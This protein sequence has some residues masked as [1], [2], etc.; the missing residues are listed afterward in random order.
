VLPV[1]D[2]PEAENDSVSVVED[3]S[4]TFQLKATD[5]DGDPL[6]YILVTGPAHGCLELDQAT[7]QV[8]YRPHEDY[9]GADSFRFQVDDGTGEQNSLSNE[10]TVSITVTPL[11]AG[12]DF[13]GGLLTV[14]GTPGKDSIK[15]VVA[16]K[17]YKVQTN[18]GTFNVADRA[19]VTRVVVRARAGDD[20]VNVAPLSAS[21]VV[22]VY[23]GDG[24]DQIT[25]GAGNSILLGGAGNDMLTGGKGDDLLIG[26]AGLD[27][28]VGAAGSDLLIAGILNDPCRELDLRGVLD[29]WRVVV[30][31]D[32]KRAAAQP[33][34][35]RVLDDLAA[36]LLS[37]SAGVDLFVWS[38][39][40]RITDLKR[41]D[42]S[43]KL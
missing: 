5:V 25:G 1:N 39:L 38:T 6:T 30:G 23:A 13:A 41:E 8:T 32:A 9:V 10:A 28:L 18:F 37:G 16:G 19:S 33:L 2:S 7:G 24:N 14:I 40:D 21:Q 15:L 22:E 26:G 43:V 27:R 36:D 4:V 29:R 34:I 3:G 35:D 17:G 12:F 11:V 20:T 31:A 42:I